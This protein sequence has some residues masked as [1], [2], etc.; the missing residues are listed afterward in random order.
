MGFTLVSELYSFWNFFLSDFSF[1]APL[2]ERDFFLFLLF[3][4]FLVVL[5]FLGF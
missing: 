3:L 1:L 4:N 2:G 5:G